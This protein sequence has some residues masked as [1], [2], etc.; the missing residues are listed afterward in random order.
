MKEIISPERAA[1]L[2]GN[3]DTVMMGGF[4]G[5]GA[6]HTV[7]SALLE[8]DARDLT[9]ISTDTATTEYGSGRLI[10]AK[11]IKRLYASH[12]GLNPETGRQ[13]NTGE[14]EVEL[15]PQGTL[16]ER[17]RSGGAGLGGV[18][19]PTGI[20][21]IVADGKQIISVDGKEYL[22]EKPL[23]AKVAVVHAQKADTR[24]NLIY[25]LSARNFNPMMA[26]AADIVIAEVNEIVAAGELDPDTIHT[27]GVFV[28]YLVKA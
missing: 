1:A 7:I 12:I 20:G 2:I 8:T 18:L 19:T 11:R 10:A 22:L 13:M 4:M 24:G 23:R 25:R 16:A 5:C 27:D 14:L 6:P 28:D 21:T 17:I 3:G 15:V 26:T 9:L